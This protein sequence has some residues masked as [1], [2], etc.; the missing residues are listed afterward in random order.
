MK[1]NEL[2]N[3]ELEKVLSEDTQEISSEYSD[4]NEEISGEEISDENKNSDINL[5]ENTLEYRETD[6][7][8]DDNTEST[9]KYKYALVD[10]E[11]E[12][13][14]DY[15]L[16]DEYSKLLEENAKLKALKEENQ[17]KSNKFVITSNVLFG[18][19]YAYKILQAVVSENY[20][21]VLYIGIF[22]TIC[23]VISNVLRIKKHTR[24]AFWVQLIPLALSEVVFKIIILFS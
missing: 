17:K 2:E 22:A 8:E 10:D 19:L 23:I 1:N 21:S 18:L 14:N 6:L 7:S 5:G 15:F 11:E 9:I 16:E 24:L 3:E 12:T 13:N 4:A 20:P